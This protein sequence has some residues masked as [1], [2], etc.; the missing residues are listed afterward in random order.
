VEFKRQ[1]YEDN[2]EEFIDEGK[3]K[4]ELTNSVEV[5]ECCYECQNADDP[6]VL[7][8][9]D[10][11]GFYCCHTYCCDP[12]LESVPLEDWFC[13]F[14]TRSRRRG[15]RRGRTTN[16]SSN[17]Q[18]RNNTSNTTRRTNSRTSRNTN[19]NSNSN[20]YQDTQPSLLERLFAEAENGFGSPDPFFRLS[21]EE[22]IP[23]DDDH[24]E[25]FDE[26]DTNTPVRARGRRNIEES[27]E[28]SPEKDLTGRR[29]N[30]NQNSS[31][32]NTNT[33]IS[34]RVNRQNSTTVSIDTLNNFR[35]PVRNHVQ[36]VNS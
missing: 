18:T 5:D 19:S 6:D 8:I 3:L 16:N 30:R 27:E 1:V 9:C 33:S 17:R 29:N 15:G 13:K 28:I 36:R 22:M 12:P 31:R 32:S 26:E 35:Y 7:L 20:R 34:N 10:G 14:C 2:L 25:N 11:C 23:Y 4:D 24:L 21:E